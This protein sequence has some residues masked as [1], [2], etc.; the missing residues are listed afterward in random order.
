MSNKSMSNNYKIEGFGMKISKNDMSLGIG[1]I[2]NIICPIIK[3]IHTI[4]RF[5]GIVS[6]KIDIINR[7]VVTVNR[8]IDT[9]SK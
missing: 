3:H 4:V 1:W 8:W 9:I 2:N 5:I 6:R 7:C